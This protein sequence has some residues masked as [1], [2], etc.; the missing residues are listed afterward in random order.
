LKP[1]RSVTVRVADARGRPVGGARVALIEE[2]PM[3]TLVLDRTRADGTVVLRYPTEAKIGSLIAFQSGLGFDYVSTLLGKRG[4]TERRPLPD[5]VTL[6]LT[7]ARTVRV[8]A[9]D[10]ANR[11][12]AGIP[13]YPW[14]VQ[15]RGR[16]EEVNLGNC[17][18][19]L[20]TT[21]ASGT[22]V[23]D[24]LPADFERAIPF[25]PF[26]RGYGYA[27][28][29]AIKEGD[30]AAEVTL[31]VLR[32][33]KVSGLVRWPD[34]RP[35]AGIMVEASGAGPAHRYGRGSA[36]T[37]PDGS[38]EML[39]ES[40]EA[41]VVAVVDDRWAAPSHVG[42]LVREDQPVGGLDFQLAEGT[43]V[44]GTVTVGPE[45]RPVAN[46]WLNLTLRAGE[47]PEAI[48]KP[49]DNTYHEVRHSRG[50][51]TDA[52]GRFRFCVGP[53]TYELS[54]PAHTESATLM[55]TTQREVV[56]DFH[57]PRPELGRLAGKV[58]T[59]DGKPVAGATVEGVYRRHVGRR[60][61]EA[62]T[63]ADGTFAVERV[64]VPAVLFTRTKDRT[65]AGI[66][67]I[68]S[69]QGQVTIRVGPL[70]TAHGR[71]L[72]ENGEVVAGGRVQYGIR[73]HVGETDDSPFRTCF[74]GVVISGPDGHYT[75][76]GLVPGEEY[77]VSF[78]HDPERGP[79][80]N[81]TTVKPLRSETIE[82]GDTAF[83]Q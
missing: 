36:W 9:V 2:Q 60:D 54:G 58:L 62:T 42:V 27:E 37:R 15:Q 48:K 5:D 25:M 10:S 57:M 65:A 46:Q 70:A 30:P 14:Y 6:R 56:H 43:I 47:I 40:E 13:V 50:A 83:R 31:P 8:K 68:D 4:T 3:W 26:S 33:A 39:V 12:V 34:G 21:D 74:G 49:G 66:A 45:R 77:R 7:G 76:P 28:Q 81:L 55:V 16:P 72:N 17:D 73:V 75:L 67:R 80:S 32:R 29:V 82:L 59:E 53:G 11:P 64:L 71:L 38:Y 20:V 41:Y 51:T 52:Q 35:A 78:E 22:A 24:W 18:A 61:I 63:A 19:A 44:R 69:G 79:W 23:F 1:A